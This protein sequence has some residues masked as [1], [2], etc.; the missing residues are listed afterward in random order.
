MALIQSYY[1]QLTEYQKKYGPRTFLLMQVG[2][3]FEVYAKTEDHYIQE[4][5][6]IG[7]LKIAAKGEHYMAGFRDYLLDKYTLKLNEANYT[8]VVHVQEEV[9]GVIRRREQAVYSPGTYFLEEDVRL[10]N[11]VCC[12][13]IHQTKRTPST[14]LFG[15]STMD[16]YTGK[17]HVYEYQE[18]YY[19]NPTT[20]DS[21]ERFLSVYHPSEMVIVHNM[22]QEIETIVQYLS[23]GVRK[24]VKISLSSKE[25]WALQASKC[26]S[27][28]YQSLIV[29]KFY[30]ALSRQLIEDL[31]FEKAIAFQS[32]CFLL[33]YV[34]VH[35]PALTRHI[36]EP[37]LETP[38]TMV[39]ANHSLK[40]L[41][42]IDTD[43][44]GEYSSVSRFLNTCRT[45]IGKREFDRMLF[46]PSLDPEKLQQSYD[47]TE[48]CCAKAYSWSGM[49]S[50][51]CDIEKV[52]RKIVLGK[53]T[54][55][56]YSQL[57]STC[58]L[59]EE[60]WPN[61]EIWSTFCDKTETLEELHQVQERLTRFFDMEQTVHKHV[62]DDTCDTLIRR[63]I[64]IDLDQATKDKLE[65]RLKFNAIQDCL[66]HLYQFKDPKCEQAF[67]L[68]ETDKSGSCLVIT[69][70]RK[71]VIEKSLKKTVDL[72]FFSDY[73]KK[74][75]TFTFSL[76]K[77][78]F[79][80]HN[81]Q[82]YEVVSE[83]LSSLTHMMIKTEYE[84]LQHLTRVYKGIH[85]QMNFSYRYLIAC[86]QKMD[87]YHTKCEIAKQYHYCKPVLEKQECSFLRAKKM[88]HVLIEHLEKQEAYV[89]NDV[90]LGPK[91]ILLF[92]TNA[93]GKTSLIKSI[94]ICIILAQA[95]L[96]VPCDEFVF[97]PY[98]YLFTRII[99]NDNMFKGL[100]TFAVEMS[101]LR[102]IL[103]KSNARSLVLGDE[104][105]SGT[106]NDSALSIFMA[107]IEHL[108]AAKSS[109]IFATHF[110]AIQHFKEIKEMPNLCLMHL[111]VRY[112]PE[113]QK[114]FYGR[115]LQEG[116]GESVYGLE[117]CKSLQLPEAFLERAY[118]L[119]NR[120]THHTSILTL[121]PCRYNRDKIV[122]VCEFCKKE[123][124]TETH[125]LQYQKE[126][127]QDYIG[128]MEKNHPS[129]LA[130]I[131]ETCHKHI[132][133]LNLV[134]EKRKNIDGSYSILLLKG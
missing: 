33:E 30:P 16:I 66:N 111:T 107:G 46:H 5:S 110:H 91:G 69:K 85:A 63:G 49:L 61:D 99:G 116:A 2:S 31:L 95:G 83:E 43:Y 82:K 117:V 42:M 133:A 13:W 92:G 74:D 134:Y 124:G 71:A 79:R 9:G 68:H 62:L 118:A 67:A 73:S 65:S 76:D 112:N 94:G 113:L 24:V 52:Y 103:Q 78:T 48:H 132:H 35:N 127:V 108:Y 25:E 32:L 75:E 7:D 40:Q 22:E 56:D 19:Q 4:F 23:K 84:F 60:H 129:N 26:E 87:V 38:N 86:I 15:I 102:V 89:P 96:Y 58:V 12:L 57:Y 121:K 64:D 27:Q 81:G 131:C 98:E 36:S 18:L 70:R 20:Y 8:T 14:L 114:L 6:R 130:S 90:E 115:T 34:Q 77:I 10:S 101:E 50:R 106:E 120:V 45:R 53:A 21:V 122:T 1:Q 39:L 93:V 41:N 11:H 97:C 72:T 88:R 47:M 125:H 100:S 44:K 28:S 17:V 128:T 37:E 59:I 126:A 29:E 54:P 119:R 3:F 105:C 80:E 104:L 109:F 55:H 51:I 123:M